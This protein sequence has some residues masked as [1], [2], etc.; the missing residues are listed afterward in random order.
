MRAQPDGLVGIGGA[1]IPEPGAQQVDVERVAQS[2]AEES[3]QREA[4][5]IVGSIGAEARDH[6]GAAPIDRSPAAGRRR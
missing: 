5:R 1:E 6:V 3:L 4:L 2:Q